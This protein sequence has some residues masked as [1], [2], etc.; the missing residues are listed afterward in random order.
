V[1]P[2]E[3]AQRVQRLVAV[4]AARALLICSLGAH[5][6]SICL[7]NPL[8]QH[9]HSN[10]TLTLTMA[11]KKEQMGAHPLAP[12]AAVD[13]DV[14]GPEVNSEQAGDTSPR[15]RSLTQERS[16]MSARKRPRQM[17]ESTA[18]ASL[19]NDA[20]A[21]NDINSAAH[22][23]E[24]VGVTEALHARIR[25]LEAE[26]LSTKASNHTTHRKLLQDI[27]RR[28]GVMAAKLSRKQSFIGEEKESV[29]RDN[30][31]EKKKLLDEKTS[32]RK[33]NEALKDPHQKANQ[34]WE[35]RMAEHD[36][37]YQKHLD[38]LVQASVHPSRRRV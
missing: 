4:S 3:S 8:K 27:E 38:D 15:K 33:L 7:F 6:S 1:G 18:H 21:Q 25:E 14:A 5:T 31:A 23:I 2:S 16:A 30:E 11:P 37:I 35:T 17:S 26:L 13:H 34:A 24:N 10:Y 22:T 36:A 28:E 12:I 32:L 20:I 29:M 9:S 19:T